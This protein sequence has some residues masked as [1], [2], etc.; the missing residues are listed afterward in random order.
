MY[1]LCAVASTITLIF[2]AVI[3]FWL[4]LLQQT[5]VITTSPIGNGMIIQSRG[6]G[7]VNTCS[8]SANGPHRCTGF[9]KPK[10]GR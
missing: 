4:T 3:Y 7:W 8:L 2:I 5:R 10:T 9:R 1:K 6:D